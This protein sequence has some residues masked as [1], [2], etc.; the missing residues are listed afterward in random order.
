[1]IFPAKSMVTHI[2]VFLPLI[3]WK[4]KM[5][6]T[7]LPLSLS[8]CRCEQNPPQHRA[9][10]PA[11]R[12]PAL[13]ID[14]AVQCY[15]NTWISGGRNVYNWSLPL[16]LPAVA[17]FLSLSFFFLLHN[18]EHHRKSRGEHTETQ[19]LQTKRGLS[20]SALFTVTIYWSAASLAGRSAATLTVELSG[21]SLNYKHTQRTDILQLYTNTLLD[22]LIYS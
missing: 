21:C 22:V 7:L 13:S 18:T 6:C 12:F 9:L 16:W 3:R 1:M 15:R 20:R 4:Q 8:L 5:Y 10:D 17:F 11:S 19:S 14:W 2:F